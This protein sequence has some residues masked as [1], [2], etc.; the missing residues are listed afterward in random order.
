MRIK[1]N[2]VYSKST[3]RLVG[4]TEMKSINDEFQKFQDSVEVKLQ[5]TT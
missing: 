2:L 4:F 3:D 5:A 1:S